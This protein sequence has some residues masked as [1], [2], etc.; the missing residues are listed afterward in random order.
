ML[1]GPESTHQA[2]RDHPIRIGRDEDRA[3]PNPTS[4]SAGQFA[5]ELGT[6][7]LSPNLGHESSGAIC[8]VSEAISGLPISPSTSQA[9]S[10]AQEQ[11]AP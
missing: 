7:R 1:L 8:V 6:D 9:F 11:E 4:A 5:G 10:R 3:D 2:T